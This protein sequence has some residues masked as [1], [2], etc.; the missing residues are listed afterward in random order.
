MKIEERG[1][2]RIGRGESTSK[3]VGIYNILFTD[4]L[5]SKGN[6]KAAAKIV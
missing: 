1:G 3:S 6:C 4:T 5:I 2:G